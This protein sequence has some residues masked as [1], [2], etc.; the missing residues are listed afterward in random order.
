MGVN[1]LWELVAPATEYR[2]LTALALEGMGLLS[3]PT[4]LYR[5][6]VDASLW[7]CQIQAAMGKGG[8]RNWQKGKNA[9]LRTL[10]FRLANLFNKPLAIVFVGDGPDR[11]GN[12][13][14]TNVGK[15]SHWLTTDM[16]NL[17][18]AFGFDWID[19]PA[20][21]EAELAS[22]SQAGLIDAV[23]SDDGD[24]LMFGAVAVIRKSRCSFSRK[25]D[26][27]VVAIYRASSILDN[28]AV[29]MTRGG[30]VLLAVLAGGD[31]NKGLYN[32]GF[33]I[34]H[35]LARYGLGDALLACVTN[36]VDD[37][38]LRAA[39]SKWRQE[40]LR[41]LRSDP[42]GYIGQRCVSLAAAVPED[43][44]VPSIVCAYARPLTTSPDNFDLAE[45]CSLC[46][47]HFSWDEEELHKR[48]RKLVWPGAVLRLF[49]DA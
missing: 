27:D 45:I 11:P 2:D 24:T 25:E 39:L 37:V 3:S 8:P 26:G 5:V 31:Y 9:E 22:M 23:L 16:K 35:G 46:K 17:V 42:H 32:C 49:T 41:L 10:F 12:K 34:A 43:F 47:T 38:S 6:G 18:V 20:E 36:S 4:T 19:A 7:F 21:A 13:R 28:P 1:G 30:L 44:P 33:K 29:Q 15:K 40:L 14:D 48:M